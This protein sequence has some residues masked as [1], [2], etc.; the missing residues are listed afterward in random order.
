MYLYSTSVRPGAASPVKVMD[1][2]IK[3]TEKVNQIGEV[4]TSLWTSAMSPSMG[5]LA[6]TSVVSDL[7]VVEATETKLA[8]DSGYLALVE[9]ASGFMSGE[10]ADQRLMQLLHADPD[11]ANMNAHYAST[12]RATVAPGAMRAGIEAGIELAQQ[13]RKVTGRPTSFAVGVTGDYG[14]VMWV[15]LSETVQQLQA[16]NEALNANEDF[17]KAVDKEAGKLYLP[18]ATQTIS[19]K[20]V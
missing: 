18:G 7:A 14:E 20:I 1:W 10:A 11:A 4:P 12:V 15:S 3:M 5:T 9:E 8:A 13:A 17:A 16:A 2:A 6:W 19:R